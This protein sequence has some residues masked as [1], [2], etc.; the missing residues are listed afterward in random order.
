M[1]L[2]LVDNFVFS[3]GF[4]SPQLHNIVQDG[5]RFEH[6][7]HLFRSLWKRERKIKSLKNFG[8]KL[9]IE[10][11]TSWLGAHTTKP[12]GA[13]GLRSRRYVIYRSQSNPT[14]SLS[15]P[16]WR[17]PVKGVAGLGEMTVQAYYL[18]GYSHYPLPQLLLM[19]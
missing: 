12:L 19:L 18:S 9:G 1:R 5:I 3:S 15:L 10:P 7:K 4:C 6:H 14:D 11:K 16:V 2:D 8:S 17:S 13:L